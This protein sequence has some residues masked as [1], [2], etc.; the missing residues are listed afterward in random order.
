MKTG[1]PREQFSLLSI[2]PTTLT[3]ISFTQLLVADFDQHSTRGLLSI[4]NVNQHLD[5]G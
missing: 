1:N 3:P 2:L 4:S 5:S